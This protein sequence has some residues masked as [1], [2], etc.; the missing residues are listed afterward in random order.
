[1]IIKVDML[2]AVGIG[3][4]MFL[5]GDFIVKKVK[6]LQK[7][8]IPAP[9]VGGLIFAL[10]HTIGVKTGTFTFQF[11][12][13]LKNFF[14]IGFFSTIG[15]TASF[16][17]I[18]QGGIAIVI[19]L[20]ISVIMLVI[21]NIWGITIARA[22]KLNPL[23]GMCAGS[24][25]L[26]GG[27]GT[28]AAL[29]PVIEANG[30]SGGLTIAVASATFGLVMG[31]I[32]S[33]PIAKYLIDKKGLIKKAKEEEKSENGKEKDFSEHHIENDNHDTIKTNDLSKGFILIMLAMSIGSVISI[34][35]NKTGLV[36]P[37]YVGAIFAAAIIR[38]LADLRKIS[39][40]QKEISAVGSVFLNIFLAM[41]IMSLEIWKI[42]RMALPLIIILLGQMI[43]LALYS[44]IVVYNFTGRNYDSAVMSAGF[45][46]YA[47]GAT[48]NA[49]ASMTAVVDKYNRPSP[50]AFFT[51]PIVGGFAIDLTMGIIVIGHMNLILSGSL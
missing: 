38:N 13:T 19:M 45:Y 49:L 32:V 3:V 47:M 6:L 10:I 8:C 48:P 2:Q 29:G 35:I 4:I 28:A 5:I 24:I 39:L 9:I 33:G 40:P 25:S 50:K 43:L 42:A 11:D 1:M 41:T 34:L 27:V 14:M 7:Y 31:G 21:Q 20:F 36:F 44:I 18:K 26:M 37:A 51:I 46:G 15:F 23:I 12:Q 17:I 16:K 22:F 30:A